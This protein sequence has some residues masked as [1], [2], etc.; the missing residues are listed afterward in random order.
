MLNVIIKSFAK[1]Q[2]SP[3]SNY[4]KWLR[5]GALC[6][7]LVLHSLC[8]V[9]FGCNSELDPNCSVLVEITI[10]FE[11]F[12]INTSMLLCRP[13]YNILFYIFR[14]MCSLRGWRDSHDGRLCRS[15]PVTSWRVPV[16]LS[17]RSLAFCYGKVSGFAY[18]SLRE[19]KPAVYL[20]H[21]N[22]F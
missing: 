12:K 2:V 5:I 19:H 4:L 17:R 9:W 15:L 8:F 13:E 20:M 11:N 3:L 6:V 22:Q 21:K 14:T 16:R 18:S 7:P 10:Q 1:I